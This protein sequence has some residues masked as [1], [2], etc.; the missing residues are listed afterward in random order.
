MRCLT[1]LFSGSPSSAVAACLAFLAFGVSPV[2]AQDTVRADPAEDAAEAPGREAPDQEAEEGRLSEYDFAVSHAMR[3]L[4]AAG[5]EQGRVTVYVARKEGEL[6]HVYFGSLDVNDPSFQVAYDVVQD[7]PGSR[8]FTVRRFEEDVSAD[9][10]LTRAALALVTAMGAFE[11]ATV[12]F[13]T[14]VWRD[15]SGRWVTYF[16]P[17]V[18][19]RPGARSAD[20][21]RRVVVSPDARR[22]LELRNLEDEAEAGAGGRDAE[23]T[24]PAVVPPAPTMSDLLNV[25]FRPALAPLAVVARRLVCEMNWEGELQNCLVAPR[26]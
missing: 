7:E 10:E 23:A 11:P 1:T 5:A 25:F 20:V 4:M 6:W 22:V 26:R 17:E 24:A 8:A 2:S 14:Y 12:R 9:P 16:A 3:A 15:A 18:V 19:R 21:N 13:H